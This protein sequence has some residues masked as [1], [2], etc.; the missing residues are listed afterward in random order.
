MKE[1]GVKYE[2]GVDIYSDHFLAACIG[3][4]NEAS[5]VLDEINVA[6]RPWATKPVK[7]AT[8]A[9]AREAIDVFFYFLEIMIMLGIDPAHLIELYEDKWEINMNRASS[10]SKE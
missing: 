9:V 4:I 3:M 1:L 8:E 5:E 7:E 10:K 6:T 2:G